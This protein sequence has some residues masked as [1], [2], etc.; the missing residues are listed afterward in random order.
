VELVSLHY[1]LND[2]ILLGRFYVFEQSGKYHVITEECYNKELT[3]L[4]NRRTRAK[5]KNTMLET[6]R[7]GRK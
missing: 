7:H 3:S 2:R 5:E 4:K 1:L 6:A